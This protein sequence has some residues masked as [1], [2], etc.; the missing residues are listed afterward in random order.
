MQTFLSAFDA[1]LA[2]LRTGLLASAAAL[3]AVCALDWMVRTRKL[4]PFSP[5]ARFMR[6][7]I[8]PL[9]RP[10]ERR[11]VRAGGLP[12]ERAVVGA[13][14]RRAGGHRAALPARVRA[15]AVRLPVRFADR[16]P[17]RAGAA[18]RSPG[19]SRSSRSRCS[20]ACS[21]RG[22]PRG[23]GAWYSRWSYALT[24]PILK[25]LRRIIPDDRHDGRHADRGVVP[26]GV[27]AGLLVTRSCD[28]CLAARAL[29]S[30]SAAVRRRAC[31]SRCACSR[32]RAARRRRRHGDALRVRVN[33]PPVDGAAN[34]A[35]IEVLAKALGVAK[36][37]VT[38]VSGATSRTKVVEVSGLTAA[39]L[40]ARLT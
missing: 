8:D 34:E 7:S 24:E 36:R 5:V 28:P 21:S 17:R 14:R 27:A 4:S 2:A 11:V 35:V 13:R 25:P 15:L 12:C 22:F 23:P 26:A 19:S 32:D 30:R 37:A 10:V 38:I 18:P 31:D 3:A 6:A 1:S 29:R 16:R 39:D 9:L 40:R 33:A 20:C